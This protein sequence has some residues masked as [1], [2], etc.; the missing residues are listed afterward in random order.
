MK[1]MAKNVTAVP[2]NS[3]NSLDRISLCWGHLEN[4][5][6]LEIV[7]RVKEW[8][9][10]SNA[11]FTPTT[12]IA[13]VDDAP[14][15]MIEFLP[16]RLLKQ[17]GLCPCRRDVEHGET[18]DRYIMGKDFENYLLISCLF[19]SKD[20]QG[21]G[22]GKAL[23]NH[24]LNSKV[25]R[26]SDGVLVYVRRRDETWDSY[27]H[28]PTGPKEF[29]LKAGFTILKNLKNPTGHILCYRKPHA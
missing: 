24:F 19:V 28:W 12:F 17:L 15:G 14:V 6:K 27:I 13:Y 18:E 5:R 8:I 29:Y 1:V 9:K 20:N 3:K 7:Q 11:I 10:T 26:D 4:W 2:L 21:K 25:F 22:V 16:Q 23:L